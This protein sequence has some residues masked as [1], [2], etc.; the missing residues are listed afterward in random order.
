MGM[1]PED[2]PKYPVDYSKISDEYRK[3]LQN[4]QIITPILTK[5]NSYSSNELK[6]KFLLVAEGS[7]AFIHWT[8]VDKRIQLYTIRVNVENDDLTPDFGYC[9]FLFC[10]QKTS[11]GTTIP[12]AGEY[13][14][15]IEAANWHQFFLHDVRDLVI[16]KNTPMYFSLA[17][18]DVD[19]VTCGVN[20]VYR[21]LE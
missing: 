5:S 15:L 16:E 18:E 8:K 12:I 14:Y 9:R 13:F 1:L 17:G 2:K 11:I 4:N 3:E 7:D 10:L 21:E 20:I 6:T 19:I